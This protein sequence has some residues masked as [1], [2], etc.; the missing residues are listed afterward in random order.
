MADLP[1]YTGWA[2]VPA[3]LVTATGLKDLDL[4]R[5]P[6][7][8]AALVTADNY[9]GKRETFDLYDISTSRPTTASAKQLE[10]AAARRKFTACTECGAR[11]DDGVSQITGR[12][13]AC[14]YIERLREAQAKCRQQRAGYARWAAERLDDP[15]TLVAWIDEH[16]P[17]P[18]ASKPKRKPVAH[19]LT[20]VT[21]NGESMLRVTHRLKDVGPRVRAVPEGAVAYEQAAAAVA[22]L[23]ERY[24]VAWSQKNLWDLVYMSTGRP[25]GYAAAE[26]TEMSFSVSRWRGDIDPRRPEHPRSAIAP[27]NADRL[28]LLLRRMAADTPLGDDSV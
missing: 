25:P 1:E 7:P 12:C 13:D 18:T 23:G 17:P 6:G 2:S 22:A 21:P 9:R 10:A 4:P 19:T 26:G 27:G 8:L 5:K 20:I 16:T 11:P 14:R 15:K 28:A 3:N 24:F